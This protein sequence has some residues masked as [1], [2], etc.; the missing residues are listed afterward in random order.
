MDRR[1]F[2]AAL[3]GGLL[4]TPG[5]LMAQQAGKVPRIGLLVPLSR[6][7]ASV[8][9][10]ALE[11]GFR[12]L[13]YVLGESI[14]LDYRWAEG[15]ADRL[16][17]LAAELVNSRM[18]VIVSVATQ[19]TLAAK[20]ATTT[21]PIVTVGAADP[22][23]TGL[24]QTLARPGGNVTGIGVHQ[25]EFAAKL[26]ELLK[27]ALPRVSRIGYLEDPSNPAVANILVV[28]RDTAKRLALQLVVYDARTLEELRAAFA[29][30]FQNATQI[31]NPSAPRRRRSL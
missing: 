24:V 25:E 27:E 31:S 28:I 1:L 22:V 21:I 3:S 20:T 17:A 2:L 9:A 15:H 11:G 13:G 29:A 30:R 19:A 26:P 6:Q 16:P 4:A 14:I 12:E 5:G 10:D 8:S 7:V 23:G 18:D